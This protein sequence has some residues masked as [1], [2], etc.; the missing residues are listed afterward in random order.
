MKAAVLPRYDKQG[1]ALDIREVPTPQPAWGQVL[2][3]VSAAGVNPLDNMI[4]RG[5]V[6]LVVPYKMPLVMGNEFVGVVEKAAPGAVRFSVGDRV[7]ARMPLDSIGA[8]AEYVAIDEAACAPVPAYLSDEEAACVPLT[9]LTAQQAYNLMDVQAG[10]TLFISGATGSLGAMAIPLAKPRGLKVAVS[11]S[12]SNEERVRALGAD[13]FVDYRTQR[14]E[15]VLSN[16]DY[17]LDSLGDAAL[18]EEFAILKEGGKLVS[19]RGL[20]NGAFARR[21]DMPWYKRVLFGLAGWKYDRMAARKHQTYDFLFVHADGKGLE[22]AASVLAA[23][24]VRPSVDGVFELAQVN[25][26]LAKVA[27]GGSHGKT[28]LRIA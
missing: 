13:A 2:V 7:F 28:V 23:R 10:S 18:P 11:G 20:P 26:A 12:A 8:F 9:A 24:E 1:C 6:K 25:E 17:V 15:D 19:L 21:A 22:G 5:E 16:V 14:I 4:V 3:R 27:H